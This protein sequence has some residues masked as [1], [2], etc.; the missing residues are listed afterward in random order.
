[1]RHDIPLERHSRARTAAT[2][3]CRYRLVDEFHSSCFTYCSRMYGGRCLDA[4]DVLRRTVGNTMFYVCGPVASFEAV[5]AAARRFA[6]IP[7][8]VRYEPFFLRKIGK[9]DDPTS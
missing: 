1:M 9:T 4:S 2:I 8:R 6:T 5:F 3:P 7:E